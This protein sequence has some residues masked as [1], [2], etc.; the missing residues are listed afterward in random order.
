MARPEF[1]VRTIPA[2]MDDAVKKLV[3][4][5]R[6]RIIKESVPDASAQKQLLEINTAIERLRATNPEVVGAWGLGCGAGCRTAPGVTVASPIG[7]IR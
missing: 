3:M 6:E 4:E 2:S 1:L 7:A 5:N